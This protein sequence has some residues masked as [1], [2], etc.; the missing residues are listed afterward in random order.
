MVLALL[1]SGAVVVLVLLGLFVFGLRR[2]LIQRAGGTFDCS[3][4]WDVTVRGEQ[5][6][7]AGEPSGKGWVYGVARY[8]GDR[9]EW[10]R[11]FS[12]AP[13]PR[14][15]LERSAIEVIA[16]RTPQGEEELALLS[17]AVVLACSHRGTQLELAMSEDA[18]TGFLAWLE[19]A[20]PGQRVNVA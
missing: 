20:P 12:Y 15:L 8:S 19:A 1:V 6:A 18:L 2:R 5:D 9:V 7:A 4:R 10:F 11:V 16:R 14:R 17:D 3:L 13:R